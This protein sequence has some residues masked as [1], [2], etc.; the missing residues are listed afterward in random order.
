MYTYSQLSRHFWGKRINEYSR[1]KEGGLLGTQG[2]IAQETQNYSKRVIKLESTQSRWFTW[3]PG[4]RLDR[5]PGGH[6]WATL[7]QAKSKGDYEARVHADARDAK[8][9]VEKQL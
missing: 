3:W 5:S 8:M 1:E 7:S 6:S 4:I 9:K 2:H